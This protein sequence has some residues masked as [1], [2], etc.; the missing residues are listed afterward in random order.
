MPAAGEPCAEIRNAATDG[1]RICS[2][3]VDRLDDRGEEFDR[4]D[5]DRVDDQ[6]DVIDQDRVPL[7]EVWTELSPN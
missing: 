6:L 5:G 3:V 2:G 7:S 1:F 4:F